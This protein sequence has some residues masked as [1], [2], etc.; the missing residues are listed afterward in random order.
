M[1]KGFGTEGKKLWSGVVASFDLT[2]AD[3]DKLRIL[4]DACRTGDLVKRLD[5]AAARAPLT[6]RGSMG[7]EAINPLIGQAQTSRMQLAQLLA[8]LNFIPAEEED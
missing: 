5:D 6:V 2:T 8:R 3:P 1:P 4:Y 7:Q